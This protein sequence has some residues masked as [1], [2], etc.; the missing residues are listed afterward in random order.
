MVEA[1]REHKIIIDSGATSH[2]M[3]KDLNLPTEG[4]FNKEVYLP[5]IAKLRTSRLTKLPFETL[6]NAA[7][8]AG[9]LPGLK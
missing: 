6:T 2:F 3:S 8:E 1:R 5:N 7:R 9:I 4:A